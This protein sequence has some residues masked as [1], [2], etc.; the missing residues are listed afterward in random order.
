MCKM[1][2]T[3]NNDEKLTPRLHHFDE[4]VGHVLLKITGHNRDRF[5]FI[6]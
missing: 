5:F 6:H 1:Q 2:E 4:D 3:N